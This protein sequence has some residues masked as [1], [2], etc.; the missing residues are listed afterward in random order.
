[1]TQYPTLPFE[2][3]WFLIAHISI[4]VPRF[5]QPNQQFERELKASEINDIIKVAVAECNP[6]RA[7]D[8]VRGTSHNHAL[9]ASMPSPT[10]T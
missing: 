3:V 9:E 8:L 6:F 1:M 7:Q 4:A 5:Y 2:Q 10:S